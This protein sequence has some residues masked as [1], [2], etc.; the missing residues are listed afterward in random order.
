MAYS[1]VHRL[2]RLIAMIQS[3]RSWNAR[4]LAAECKTTERTIYRDLQ[5][6]QAAGIPI[7]YNDKS[8]GY[9]ILGSFFMQPVQLT[10]EEALALS[11]LCEHIAAPE[12]IPFLKPAWRALHK[13][14]SQLPPNIQRDLTSRAPAFLIKTAQAMQPDGYADVYDKVR[15]A[16]ADRRVL[17]CE[18]EPASPDAEPGGGFDFRPYA[19][20]YAVRAWY[21]VGHRSDRDD[22]RSLK[23]NRFSRIE[24]T[25]RSYDIPK[26]FDLDAHLGN[27]WRMISD[28]DDVEVE[29]DFD[30]EFAQTISDTHW[31]R[32]QT[33]D[34]HDDGSCTFRCTVS[35]L[36]EIEWWVL[37]MGPHCLVRRPSELAARVAELARKT[38]GLYERE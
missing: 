29:I 16:I 25:E 18:Y 3:G 8:G 2:L 34:W 20:F 5:E 24:L 12:Q 13:V 28:G 23:L 6:L 33:I 14:E 36:A 17:W 38:A 4:S 27:A 35:G 9:E 15:E 19:L 26:G 31:H 11:A 30:P 21:A 7:S 10:A 32:T 37:S 1:R 22:L